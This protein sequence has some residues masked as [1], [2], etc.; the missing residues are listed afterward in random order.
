MIDTLDYDFSEWYDSDL[1]IITLNGFK[2]SAVRNLVIVP[3]RIVFYSL[4]AIAGL[5]LLEKEAY[6][7]LLCMLLGAYTDRLSETVYS[8]PT[9][10]T[11][12]Y[13][14]AVLIFM[15]QADRSIIIG[16]IVISVAI[17]I[18][19]YVFKLLG[20]GDAGIFIAFA[21][22]AAT[23][24]IQPVYMVMVLYVIAAIYF[25]VEMLIKRFLF[26]KKRMT[27]PFA[28]SML[29]AYCTLYGATF[30]FRG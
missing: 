7:L 2:Y 28:P 21:I 25:C 20:Q 30:F 4:L 27:G 1:G 6:A 5:F 23:L 19:S 11:I 29:G 14:L 9:I 26:H 16:L 12:V 3:G 10:V 13:E 15:G 22:H 18:W 24:Q 8:L 17:I